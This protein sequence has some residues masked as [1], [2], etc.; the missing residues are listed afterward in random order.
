MAR[1]GFFHHIGTFLLFAATVLLIITDISAPVVARISMLRVDLDGSTGSSN[2]HPA[3]TFG[4]FGWCTENV[5]SDDSKSCSKHMIGYDP[6]SVIQNN[7]RNVDVGDLSADTSK[8]LTNVMVLHP[9]A[10]GLAFISFAMAL[11]AG[12]VGSFLASLGALITFIVTLVA[13]V[14]DFVSFSIVMH[15]VNSANSGSRASWG[16]ASWTTLVSAICSLLATIILFFT[17]CSA[18]IHRKREKRVVA[19]NDAGVPAQRGWF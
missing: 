8:G 7:V 15:E 13:L 6:I 2:T 11:G 14:C 18:R 16:T 17:C 4:T 5:A 12:L 10:T 9:V 19:K 3:V 1:T